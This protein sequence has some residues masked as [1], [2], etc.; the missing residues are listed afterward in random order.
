MKL[1]SINNLGSYPV[2][3]LGK[4]WVDKRLLLSNNNY[5]QLT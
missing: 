2:L 1:V 4:I 3:R 5:L